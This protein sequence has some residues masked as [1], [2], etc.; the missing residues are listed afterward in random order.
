VGKADVDELSRTAVAVMQQMQNSIVAVAVN[1]SGFDERSVKTHRHH[2]F[3]GLL[4]SGRQCA[5]FSAGGIADLADP[6]YG[7]SCTLP[8]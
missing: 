3:W 8:F 7:G 6:N 4:L 5:M 2:F 1:L